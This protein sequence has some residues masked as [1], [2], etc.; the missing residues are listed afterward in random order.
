MLVR[1][2]FAWLF[3]PIHFFA[4]ELVEV[5]R[6][7]SELSFIEPS[8]RLGCFSSQFVSRPRVRRGSSNQERVVVHRTVGSSRRLFK[9][10]P[11]CFGFLLVYPLGRSSQN[12]CGLL[13]ALPA[14]AQPVNQPDKQ[15]RSTFSRFRLRRAA[16]V[17]RLSP[18]L[19]ISRSAQ[20]SL[21]FGLLARPRVGV[22]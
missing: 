18:T 16:V 1:R 2:A 12:A 9:L 14:D 17:C 19:G 7:K 4:H 22:H 21:R 8:A 5:H 20:A 3:K 10:G 6:V 15:R 11:S 13:L